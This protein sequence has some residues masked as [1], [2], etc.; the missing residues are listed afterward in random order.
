ML[1]P[2]LWWQQTALRGF[3]YPTGCPSRRHQFTKFK[4]NKRLTPI[5]QKARGLHQSLFKKLHIGSRSSKSNS[6]ASEQVIYIPELLENILLHLPERDLLVNAQRVSQLWH[7]I[8]TT[9]RSLQQK[10][11]FQPLPSTEY[12]TESIPNP[13]LQELFPPWFRSFERNVPRTF[14]G[15]DHFRNLD[16]NSSEAKREAYKRKDASWRRMLVAQPPVLEMT[17]TNRYHLGDRRFVRGE[18]PGTG[19]RIM[20]MVNSGTTAIPEGGSGP[21]M[22]FGYSLRRLI[23]G[24]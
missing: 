5:I 23:H 15:R 12:T 13:I 11:Y 19:E 24:V 1:L 18:R 6:S 10:L 17:H 7:S 3:I 8:I 22:R 9:F 20:F 21:F 4:M 2:K 16:W 14:I